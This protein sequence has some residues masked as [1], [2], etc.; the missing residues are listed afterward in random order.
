MRSKKILVIGGAGFIGSH[1]VDSLLKGGACVS[2]FDNF[3]TGQ[4]ENLFAVAHKISIT[5]GDI[6]DFKALKKAMRGM[7]IVSHHAA[8]LEIIRGMEDPR[9]DLEVNTV[10]TLNILDAAKACGVERLIFASSSAVYGQGDDLMAENSHLHPNWTYGVSKLAAEKYCD[11]YND[12]YGLPV[13]SLRYGIVYGEREWYRRVLTIFVKRAVLGLPLVI[14]GSGTQVRDFI[15]VGDVVNLHNQC[16]ASDVAV[17]NVYNVGSGVGTSI[18]QLAHEVIEASDKDLRIE[19]E[20]VKE[21]AYSKLIPDRRRNY[22]ELKTLVL[23]I[24]R[25]QRQLGWY[26]KVSLQ[27]GIKKTLTWA[28]ENI[29]RWKKVQYSDA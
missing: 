22:A 29:D 26:P 23:D 1:I 11:I 5:Q 4:K 21:G 15:Y 9:F 12:Y 24:T 10:G 14:F 3:S 27:G 17:G 19:H 8:Q 7:D 2:V 18:E 20:D 28:S 6:L 16:L 13:V 25:T